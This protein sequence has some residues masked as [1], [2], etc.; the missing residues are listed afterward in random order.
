MYSEITASEQDGASDLKGHNFKHMN[1]NI[2][3]NYKNLFKYNVVCMLYFNL[4]SVI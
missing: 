3:L 2:T 1:N 4:F